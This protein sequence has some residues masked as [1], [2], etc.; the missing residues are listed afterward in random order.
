MIYLFLWENYFRKKQIKIWKEAFRKKYWDINITHVLNVSS[1]DINFYNQNLLWWSFFSDK[2]LFII[3]DFFLNADDSLK[4][5]FLDLIDKIPSDYIL[6][7]NEEK[8][9]KKEKLYKKIIEIWEIKDFSI[10]NKESLQKYLLKEFN[11]KVNLNVINKLIELKWLNF[12]LISKEIEKI[13]ILKDK[14]E[15]SDLKNISKDIEENIFELINFIMNDS[16][17]LRIEKTRTMYNFL[18]NPYYFYSV[19]CSQ[20][21]LHFY[22]FLLKSKNIKSNDIKTILNLKNRWFLVDK[23]YKISFEKFKIIYNKLLNIDSKIKS[24][25]IISNNPNDII[26]EIEKCFL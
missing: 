2:K 24:W 3:D 16:I 6:V 18:D 10:N 9:D 26:F 5:Y 8:V 19:L 23:N 14:V 7:F 17:Y 12:L 25:K 22:I 1:F 15:I 11:W 13:L 4:E 21:R 20:L